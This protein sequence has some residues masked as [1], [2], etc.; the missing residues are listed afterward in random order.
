MGPQLQTDFDFAEFF[1][2]L[3][4]LFERH[5]LY[6]EGYVFW[7]ARGSFLICLEGSGGDPEFTGEFGSL[8]FQVFAVLV[9][10]FRGHGGPLDVTIR[11]F[12]S[13]G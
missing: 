10:V 4:D 11:R 12:P 7:D 13:G 6:G 8:H 3:A 9:D 1:Q 5:G 2:I